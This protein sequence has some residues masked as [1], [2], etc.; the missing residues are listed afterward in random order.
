V[1][2]QSFPPTRSKPM[3]RKIVVQ[4]AVATVLVAV[5]AAIAQVVA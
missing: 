1:S 2:A 5:V 3:L 4:G